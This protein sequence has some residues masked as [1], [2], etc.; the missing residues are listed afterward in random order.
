MLPNRNS[1]SF[2]GNLTDKALQIPTRNNIQDTDR[3]AESDHKQ[4]Q[5]VESYNMHKPQSEKAKNRQTPLN[6]RNQSS[7]IYD[8]V[9]IT[10][11]QSFQDITKLPHISSPKIPPPS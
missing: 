1:I 2:P 9:Q 4:I 10:Q 8:E 6:Q 7:K 11:T 5:T 3:N